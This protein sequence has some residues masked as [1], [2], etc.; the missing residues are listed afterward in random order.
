[1]YNMDL[2][3]I[4]RMYGVF[5]DCCVPAFY[6]GSL[7]MVAKSQSKG[8]IKWE[9]TVGGLLVKFSHVRGGMMNRSGRETILEVK[10]K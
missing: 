2:S 6:F 10:L 5:I 4:K 3:V 7:K 9:K 8:P 1:M